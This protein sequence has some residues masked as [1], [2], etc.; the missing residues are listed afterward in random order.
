[1]KVDLTEIQEKL[2]KVSCP[3]C[4]NA[5]IDVSLR[6]DL[7]YGEC[8]AVAGCKT[9]GTQYEIST[10]GRVLKHGKKYL[11]ELACPGCKESEIKL[12]MR[13][14]L[15]SHQCFY[16]ARCEPCNHSFMTKKEEIP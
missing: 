11:P 15:P 4:H 10:E 8:L 9:C 5:T 16:V 6:C 13:C 14:E 12:E 2:N 3:V 1:M 7:G